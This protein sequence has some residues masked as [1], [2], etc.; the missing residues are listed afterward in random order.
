MT[1]RTS[2]VREQLTRANEP[3]LIH[4]R[5]EI[6]ALLRALSRKRTPV[7][8]YYGPGDTF[9]LTT[10]L[11]FD[12]DSW[13]LVLDAGRNVEEQSNTASTLTLVAFEGSVKVQ[14]Q[15]D[16][17][18]PA[19]W[20]GMPAIRSTA[21]GTV[22]RLQRRES[23]RLRLPL[24]R[25]VRCRIPAAA[26]RGAA[27]LRVVDISCAGLGLAVAT[28]QPRFEP[29]EQLWGCELDLPGG[30]TLVVDLEV[31]RTVD[32]S[33]IAP[34]GTAARPIPTCGCRF[35]GLPGPSATQIQRYINNVDREQRRMME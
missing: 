8:A 27:D 28:D 21:P 3:Y 29:G 34:P 10:L 5:V 31:R 33:G 30:E 11:A 1:D 14:F 25:S 18:E 26:D 2:L 24:L 13:Q 12:P 15:I 32:T 19:L 23:Y 35:V 4:N 17:A 9:L 7:A 20:G 22:L 16:R 6:A